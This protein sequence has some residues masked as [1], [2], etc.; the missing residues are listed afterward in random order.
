MKAIGVSNFMPK[1]LKE[2]FEITT[3]GAPAVNQFELHAGVFHL[4]TEVLAV[5]KEH[6]ITVTGYVDG[7]DDSSTS[8]IVN[9]RTLMGCADPISAL[10]VR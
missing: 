1:H 9:S 8:F 6:N 10:S 4:D 5:C 2:I 7:T 3:T